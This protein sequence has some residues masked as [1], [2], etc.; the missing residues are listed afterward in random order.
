VW[1]VDAE[2]AYQFGE[3]NGQDVEAGFAT[4]V[5][6]HA[7]KEARWSPRIS[8]LFYYGSGDVDSQDGTTN[9][10]SVLFPLG[11]AYW[12][13]SDNLSGQNLLDYSL[14][15]DV[16]PMAKTT[17]TTAWHAFELASDDD[18]AYSVAGA[19]VGAP[20]NGR[21]LGEALDVYGSYA[22]NA[23]LDVQAGYS[24]FWYGAFI[25]RTTPRGDARQLYL[26]TSF[27]Y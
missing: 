11:H 20:G 26:Q 22:V 23:H 19:A 12:G 18:V 25:D 16:K 5:V 7:W 15:L 14:Q 21:S 13:L 1:D 8:G 17:L 10:F 24:W 27:R 2:A 6:G 3:D 4:V 9:T